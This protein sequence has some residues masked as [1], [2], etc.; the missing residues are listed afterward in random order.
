[1]VALDPSLDRSGRGGA[2]GAA[3]VQS[4]SATSNWTYRIDV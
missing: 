2:L 4:G 1:M 3:V